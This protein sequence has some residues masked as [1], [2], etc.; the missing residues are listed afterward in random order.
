MGRR[1]TQAECRL[2]IVAWPGWHLSTEQRKELDAK[3]MIINFDTW[4]PQVA[5][6]PTTS[7]IP[8]K[9]YLLEISE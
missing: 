8:S 7:T 9:G 1:N 6:A 3:G 5:H 2:M 4:P